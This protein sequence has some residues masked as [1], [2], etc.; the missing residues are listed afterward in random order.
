MSV[1]ARPR[2]LCLLCQSRHLRLSRRRIS[3]SPR[4]VQPATTTTSSIALRPEDDGFL[5]D[6]PLKNI[7][8]VYSKNLLRQLKHHGE[9]IPLEA[10]GEVAVREAALSF[11]ALYR[12]KDARVQTLRSLSNPWPEV[13]QGKSGRYQ[14]APRL[15]SPEDIHIP[16]ATFRARVKAAAGQKAVRQVLRGQ[17]LR[18][19]WPAD[20]LRVVAVAM[21]DRQIAASLTHLYEPIMRALYRCRSN[22]SDPEVLKTLHAIIMRFKYAQ[23]NVEPQLLYMALKFAARSRSKAAMKKFLKLVRET[24]LGMSSNVYRSV[25][26]KFS[27]GHR[28]LGE[29]RNGRWK[30]SEL[31]EVLLGFEDCSDLPEEQQY[32]FGSFLVREDWQYLHGWVA[33]LARCRETEGVWREWELWKETKAFREPRKLIVVDDGHYK[34]HTYTITNKLRGVCWFI[35]QMVFAGDIEKAWKIVHE[36]GVPFSRLKQRIKV[37]MLDHPEFAGEWDETLKAEMLKKYDWDLSKIESALGVRWVDGAQHGEG[38][39]ELFMDQEEA[40]EKLAG[41]R[42]KWS[43]ENGYPCEESPIVSQS[44]RELHDAEET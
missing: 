37:R 39:H 44:E 38:Q 32:H 17:L 29:I 10:L 40:L 42:W 41:D 24:G 30:R 9:S 34:K 3:T 35:E 27:I 33:V 28:G 4:R 23:L 14:H 6:S 19:S 18:S 43:E 25:I 16:H 5:L 21:Q 22:V 15:T 26:A 8:G 12:E 13:R 2:S 31:R 36:T 11:E 1:V 7:A 20:I